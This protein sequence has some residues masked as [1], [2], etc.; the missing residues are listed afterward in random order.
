MGRRLT[1]G[2]VG[3]PSLGGILA[4]AETITSDLNRDIVLDPTGTGV[5]KVAGHLQMQSQSEVRFSDADSSNYFAFRAPTTI[6][7]NVVF[8]LPAADGSSGQA[9]STNGSGVLQFL[10]IAVAVQDDTTDSNTL[11]PAFV[12]VTSGSTATFE[13]SSSKLTFQPSTG[14]LTATAFSGSHSGDGSGL[15]SVTAASVDTT[16]EGSQNSTYYPTFVGNTS[17]SQTVNA[18]TAM[19]YNP[20]S[21]E[22][23][24]TIVTGSSDITLKEE[25]NPLNNA[26]DSV[27]NLKGVQYFRKNSTRLETG[28]VAQEVEKHIPE[29]VYTNDQGLKSIAY[30]NIV[31]YLIEAI[32]EQAAEIKK[33]TAKVEEKQ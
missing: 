20:S 4:D 16:L 12:D 28:L 7:D 29:V 17:G 6:T 30:G 25:I 19:T 13:V 11:Y 15:N 9:L 33:L 14:T 32:K 21:G 22:F 27:M 8:D 23:T 31:A 18:D 10:D 2:K 1:S 3:A 26:L 5:V 24:A